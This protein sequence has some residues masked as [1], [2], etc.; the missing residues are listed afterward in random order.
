MMVVRQM[1]AEH[2][3][4]P[5]GERVSLFIERHLFLKRRWQGVAEDGTAFDFDLESRL[6]NG[7]VI[8]QT[9]DADYV[10][11]QQEEPVF[12]IAT[13]T[14]ALAALVGWKIGNLHFPVQIG[15]GFVRVT[16][17]PM[18]QELLATEDWSYEKARVVFQ[19]L[20]LPP[21]VTSPNP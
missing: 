16:V 17:D 4:R 8:H 13:P 15:E 19:P 2:S 20:K 18:I 7:C 1:L 9:D 11:A 21:Q 10:I 6:K 12:Q 5:E 3:L 14:V